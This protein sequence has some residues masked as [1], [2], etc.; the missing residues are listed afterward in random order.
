M[1]YLIDVLTNETNI[2][3]QLA[4]DMLMFPMMLVVA[5]QTG[6]KKLFA[7]PLKYNRWK[8]LS[9]EPLYPKRNKY[10]DIIIDTIE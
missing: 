1:T 5:I 10:D 6:E 7:G 4:D 2:M 8:V 9:R 3:N